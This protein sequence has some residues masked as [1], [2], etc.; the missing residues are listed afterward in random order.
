VKI[1]NLW[2]LDESVVWREVKRGDGYPLIVV[3]S[4]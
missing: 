4:N 2:T 1:A 3:F